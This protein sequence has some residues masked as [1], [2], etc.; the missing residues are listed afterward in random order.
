MFQDVIKY[1]SSKSEPFTTALKVENKLR[2][3]ANSLVLSKFTCLSA[4]E[5]YYNHNN[6]AISKIC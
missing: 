6:G 3:K 1:E 5:Y 2:N 4:R